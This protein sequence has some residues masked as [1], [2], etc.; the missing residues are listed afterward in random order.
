V[1]IN[2]DKNSISILDLKNNNNWNTISPI[3]LSVVAFFSREDGMIGAK[4]L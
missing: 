2:D 4:S 1:V 3:V